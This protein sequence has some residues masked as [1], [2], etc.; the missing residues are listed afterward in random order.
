MAVRSDAVRPRR[1]RAAGPRPL[2]EHQLSAVR[3]AVLALSGSGARSVKMHGLVVY[4]D[5][6]LTQPQV[7]PFARS[8]P[9]TA[10]QPAG[11]A[12]TQRPQDGLTSRQRRSRRRLEER[13][14]L[15]EKERPPQPPSRQEATSARRRSQRRGACRALRKARRR[16]L[17]AQLLQ[18]RVAVR[19]RRRE[20]STQP[21]P[22]DSPLS[23]PDGV[24]PAATELGDV[25][26]RAGRPMQRLSQ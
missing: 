18:P 12:T 3:R 25:V 11:A 16:S 8:A 7:N 17:P 9:A 1:Q 15:R 4:L 10:Q 2:T 23:P 20:R 26:A 6:E 19:W 13:I 24:G 22:M 5:K 21:G 14:A